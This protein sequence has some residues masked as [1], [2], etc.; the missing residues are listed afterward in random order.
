MSAFAITDGEAVLPLAIAQDFK[1]AGDG[2]TGPNTGG[3]GAYSPVPSVDEATSSEIVRL[4]ERTVL[5]LSDDGIRYQG[6][7]YGGLILTGEGP[8][9]LEFNARFGDPETQAIL[10][11]LDSDLA[12]LLLAAATGR[13]AGEKIAWRDEASVTVILASGGYPDR[14]P[15]GLPIEGIDAAAGMSDTFRLPRRNR[16]GRGR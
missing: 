3:M 9:V 7:L 12:P 2:D 16:D 8:K 11:R 15:T 10:P 6:C 4:L 5:A 14:Y 1:R 13:L